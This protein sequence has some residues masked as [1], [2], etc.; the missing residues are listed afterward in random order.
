M[1][2]IQQLLESSDPWVS[3]QKQAEGYTSKWERV[4]L[5]EGIKGDIEKGQMAMLLENQA[6]RLV[7]EQSSTNNGGATFTAGA[8]EQ[9]SSIALPLV[10]RIFGEIAAKDFVSMQ[11]MNAPAG[12]IF[13][14]DFKYGTTKTPFTSG[15]SVYGATSDLKSTDLTKGLYGNGKFSYSFNTTS[16]IHT[17]SSVTTASYADVHFNTSLSSSVAAGQ[18]KKV[19]IAA[20]ANY[21]PLGV[22]AFFI[23]SGSSITVAQNYPALNNVVSTDLVFIVSGSSGGTVGANTTLYWQRATADNSRGDFEDNPASSISIPEINVQMRSEA[24]VAETRK[25]KAQWTPEF[26]QDLNAY[27]SIDAESELTS[28]LSEYISLEIDAEILEML[29]DNAAT[30]DYWTAENN[31]AINAGATAFSALTS[32]YYNSQRDWFATLGTKI[33][34]VSNKIHQR[35]LR[36]GANFLVCSPEVATVIESIPG[37]STDTDGDKQQFNMGTV[38]AGSLSSRWKVYKVPYLTD[39]TILLGYKGNQFLECGAVFATYVP[40]IMTPLLYDPDTFTPRKG[41]MSRYAKKMIRSEFYGKI[42]VSGLNTL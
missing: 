1:K 5:L 26:S 37:Y 3:L 38:K 33:Q 20:P 17:P 36:G 24:I 22:R 2:G 13:Y 35:T 42:Y 16:S 8:G 7:L 11:T 32:G 14:L 31:Q 25:L 18:M 19:V 27:H 39:N 30:V 4:G 29:M 34:K 40:L 15:D 12:L 10:R 9:W 28:M 41:L 21:D 23:V 6:K